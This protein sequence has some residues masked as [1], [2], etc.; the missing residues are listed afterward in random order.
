MFSS[1][2]LFPTLCSLLQCGR[3]VPTSVCISAS[4]CVRVT[5]CAS[6]TLNTLLFQIDVTCHAYHQHD[7]LSE[8]LDDSLGSEDQATPKDVGHNIYILAH[9]VHGISNNI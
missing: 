8:G 1:S 6:S 7:E 9:Q 2:P 4:V 3:C 5:M